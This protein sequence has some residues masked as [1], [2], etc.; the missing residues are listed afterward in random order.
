MNSISNTEFENQFW[1]KRYEEER[2]GWDIGY[3]ST[4]LKTYFDQLD[5]PLAKILIPGAGN[6]YEAEYL[7]Q[8]GFKNVY[9]LDISKTPLKKFSERNPK[10]PSDQ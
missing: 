8:K 3:V 4:P 1:T 5:D 2:T 10:F 6:A 9:V 7:F